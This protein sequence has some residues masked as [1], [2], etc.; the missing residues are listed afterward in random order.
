M[1]SKRNQ[2]RWA[3]TIQ[4]IIDARYIEES[5][6]SDE[7][8]KCR[9]YYGVSSRPSTLHSAG[10]WPECRKRNQPR[11]NWEWGV[12]QTKEREERWKQ[13]LFRYGHQQISKAQSKENLWQATCW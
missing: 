2:E 7:S 13:L 1:L 8:M 6:P 5:R 11:L 3:F 4:L 9:R 10:G 12:H